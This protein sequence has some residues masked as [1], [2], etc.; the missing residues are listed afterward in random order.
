MRAGI[1]RAVSGV[2]VF[3]IALHTA[4]WAAMAPVSTAAAVDPFTV[5]C[6]SGAE[7]PAD[8][9]PD[10]GVPGPGHACD[11]CNLCSAATPPL[12]QT[13]FSISVEPAQVSQ[14]LRP[15]STTRHISATADPKLAR[16]PPVFA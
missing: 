14:I 3:A 6:H 10:Q 15:A 7:Q 8:P 9:S 13:A 4:L 2:A 12:P 1:R 11:H 16:G 5:I